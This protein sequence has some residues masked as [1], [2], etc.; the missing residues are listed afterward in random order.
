MSAIRQ[1]IKDAT[2]MLGQY[3]IT[4]GIYEL[5]GQPD[6]LLMFIPL[7]HVQM[8]EVALSQDELK[9]R[10]VGDT[11]LGDQEGKNTGVRID[12][13]LI[14]P[15]Q[16]ILLT[17]VEGLYLWCKGKGE[18]DKDINVTETTN[19]FNNYRIQAGNT[20]TA[21]LGGSVP[22]SGGSILNTKTL[23]SASFD[24][25]T[26]QTYTPKQT[27][28]YDNIAKKYKDTDLS[29]IKSAGTKYIHRRSFIMMTKTDVLYNMFLQTYVY[30]RSVANGTNVIDVSVFLRR[31]DPQKELN[32]EIVSKEIKDGTVNIDNAVDVDGFLNDTKI[33]YD[34]DNNKS[35]QKKIEQLFYKNKKSFINLE[36]LQGGNVKSYNT[37]NTNSYLH[38]TST[39]T[40]IVKSVK[41]QIPNINKNKLQFIFK[42]LHR[43]ASVVQRISVDDKYGYLEDRQML[44]MGLLDGLVR[45]SYNVNYGGLKMGTKVSWVNRGGR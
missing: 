5:G 20:A 31:Y 23:K 19:K 11:Y 35:H 39:K 13:R 41:S 40:S 18:L 14:G 3:A 36:Y 7:Y 42:S 1:T 32:V 34:P 26:G 17:M 25:F 4:R 15:S 21:T 29:D 37:V 43:L 16:E 22:V 30:R 10:A 44:D 27:S 24:T 9:F 33:T 12:F 6:V 8:Y 2:A 28:N 38:G 45:A